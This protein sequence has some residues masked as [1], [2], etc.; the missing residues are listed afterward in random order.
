MQRQSKTRRVSCRQPPQRDRQM[1]PHASK[2]KS[3]TR[4]PLAILHD[5]DDNTQ[6]IFNIL[7]EGTSQI[8]ICVWYINR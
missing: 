2:I 3:L 8:N 1:E 6:H 4:E 5:N 7:N